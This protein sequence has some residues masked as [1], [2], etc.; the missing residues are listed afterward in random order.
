MKTRLLKPLSDSDPLTPFHYLAVR[1]DGLPFMRC[2]M[3]SASKTELLKEL[4]RLLGTNL[5]R[6]GSVM[7]LMVDAVT[8]K[9]DEDVELFV[10]FVWNEI[11]LKC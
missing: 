7:D 2:L 9:T 10:R 5:L 6:R 11:F 8:G 3:I 4:D 1:S